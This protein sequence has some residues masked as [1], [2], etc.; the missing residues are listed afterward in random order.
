MEITI[1][2]ST[3][4]EVK[5]TLAELRELSEM[6]TVNSKGEETLTIKNTM[7]NTYHDSSR[8]WGQKEVV[9]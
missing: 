2:L 8:W 5:V 1:K 7:G 9:L 6:F 4:K 3:G